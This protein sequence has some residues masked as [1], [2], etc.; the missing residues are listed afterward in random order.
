MSPLRVETPLDGVRRVTLDHPERRNQLDHATMV[1]LADACEA[2]DRDP[3]VRCLVL[4]GHASVFAAGADLREMAALDGAALAEHPRTL[5]WRRLFAIGLPMVAAVEGPALGGG[6]ELVQT[7]DIVVAGTGA[8]FGQPEIAIGWMPGAGGTQRLPRAVGK[9]TAMQLV[10]TGDPIDAAR[11]LAA[12]LVSEVVPAGEALARAEAIAGRI[13]SRAPTAVRRAK[14]AVLAA[15][16]GPMAQGLGVE[17]EHFL[18]QA[19]SDERREGIAA[20]F[21]KRAPRYS[22]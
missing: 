16:D 22:T 18:A 5:A 6:C 11:A 8:S 14:A 12:G 17:R 9:A 4:T 1:A 3:S 15:W 19:S 10:L 21:E 7:C 20:F 2:A 13:A